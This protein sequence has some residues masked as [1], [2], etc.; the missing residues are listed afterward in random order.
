MSPAEATVPM[1]VY[2]GAGQGFNSDYHSAAATLAL[3]RTRR[4]SAST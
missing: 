3:E 4:C 2:D 1:F